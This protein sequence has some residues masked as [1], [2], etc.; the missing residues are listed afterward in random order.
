M[1]GD[2]DREVAIFTVEQGPWMRYVPRSAKGVNMSDATVMLAA[3]EAGDTKVAE[4][5]L[6]LVYDELRRLT[7]WILA[8]AA[9]DQTPGQG[10]G[11]AS[12]FQVNRGG[13]VPSSRR[14]VLNGAGDEDVPSPINFSDGHS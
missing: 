3:I 8:Q 9:P 13:D 6:V 12:V 11:R 14:T 5:L 10:K 1:N 7:A 2:S 4:Q